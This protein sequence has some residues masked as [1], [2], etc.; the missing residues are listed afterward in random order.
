MGRHIWQ[1]HGVF[2]YVLVKEPGFLGSGLCRP[3]YATFSGSPSIRVEGDSG[4]PKSPCRTGRVQVIS[5]KYYKGSKKIQVYLLRYADV[6]DT[7][8]M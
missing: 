2:E 4:C 5:S 1:S 3:I 8:I 6:F 7:V